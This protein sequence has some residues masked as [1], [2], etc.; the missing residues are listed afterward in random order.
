MLSMGS[1][2]GFLLLH[3]LQMW[4]VTTVGNIQLCTECLLI[5]VACLLIIYVFQ[6]VYKICHFCT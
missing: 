5:A 1:E 2:L 4:Q 6:L 3:H